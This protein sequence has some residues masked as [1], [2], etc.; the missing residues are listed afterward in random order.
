VTESQVS[1]EHYDWATYNLK[2]RWASYWHQIDEALRTG[3]ATCLEV[4]TGAG[5][6]R[7]TLRSLGVAVTV[8]D[9]D[10][11][12]GADR[13]SDVRDLAAGDEEFDV[14][15]CSQ[16]L[17]HVPWADVPRAVAELRRVCRTH[18]IVSLPQSGTDVAAMVGLPRLGRRQFATRIGLHRPWRFDGQHH[19]QVLARGTGR[20][21]V[22]RALSAG[23]RVEREYTVPEFTYHRFYVLRKT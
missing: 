18:A 8:V 4:G 20:R 12:L 22:R 7:D 15:L 21:A 2:G 13:V 10:A 11:A 19:W 5:V 23:F 9:I 17:E 3:A 14:V 16:V 1:L 6:V